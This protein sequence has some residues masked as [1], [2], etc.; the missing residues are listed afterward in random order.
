MLVLNQEFRFPM[1]LPYFGTSLGGA[2]FMTEATSTAERPEFPF[3]TLCQSRRS[4]I[5]RRRSA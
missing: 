5:R 1:R 2:L 3:D 4:T